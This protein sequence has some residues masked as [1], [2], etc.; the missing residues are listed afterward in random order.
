M[1]RMTAALLVFTALST[2][3]WAETP[4]ERNMHSFGYVSQA[5]SGMEAPVA[6]SETRPAGEKPM[7]HHKGKKGAHKKAHAKGKHHH[8]KKAKKA[9]AHKEETA[10]KQ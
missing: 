2:Q 10:P 4:T 7:T 8:V 6:P 5:S 3:A 9:V 1:K